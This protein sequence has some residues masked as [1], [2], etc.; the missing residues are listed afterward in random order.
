MNDEDIMVALYQALLPVS[1]G[2]YVPCSC[3]VANFKLYRKSI[4]VCILAYESTY[5]V[6][7]KEE[8][9]LRSH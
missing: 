4:F 5:F 2:A 6:A 7:Q 1:R 8:K 9:A 3:M